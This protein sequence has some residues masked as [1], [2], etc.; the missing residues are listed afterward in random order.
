MAF[1]RPPR[2]PAATP[3]GFYKGP[4]ASDGPGW[5]WTPRVVSAS[6]YPL[7]LDASL[8]ITNPR[9]GLGVYPFPGLQMLAEGGAMLMHII[10]P[11]MPLGDA[12]ILAAGIGRMPSGPVLGLDPVTEDLILSDVW[13]ASGQGGPMDIASVALPGAPKTIG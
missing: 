1:V 10:S 4:P 9:R 8:R 7:D 11:I 6:D 12:M 3:E 2:E 13:T 5:F